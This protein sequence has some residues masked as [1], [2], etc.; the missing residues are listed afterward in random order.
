MAGK[1]ARGNHREVSAGSEEQAQPK[2]L[3]KELQGSP[4]GCIWG[5]ERQAGDCKKGGNRIVE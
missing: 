4:D 2:I 3:K 1:A 5:H